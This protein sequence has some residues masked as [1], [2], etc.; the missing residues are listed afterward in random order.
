M[1][2]Y[3][4][5]EDALPMGVFQAQLDFQIQHA[6]STGHGNDG[7]TVERISWHRVVPRLGKLVPTNS[8]ELP[9]S[10][11]T[12]EEKGLLGRVRVAEVP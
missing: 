11:N 7:I 8:T 2:W 12:L 3:K 6:G 4:N 1:G 9:A 5:Q 10:L